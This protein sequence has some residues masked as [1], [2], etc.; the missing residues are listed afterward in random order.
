MES[1][2]VIKTV[3]VTEKAQ[4]LTG[5]DQYTFVVHPDATKLQI[6]RAVKELFD[7][8][9]KAVNVINV[10]GKSG[11]R[12]RYGTGRKSDWKKAVVTLKEGQEPLELF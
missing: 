4:H 10:R 7:R 1:H 3:R 11:R 5:D 12:T 8:D 9:V 6:K 2:K